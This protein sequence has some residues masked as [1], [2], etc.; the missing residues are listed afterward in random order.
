MPR[1]RFADG[2]FR[3]RLVVGVPIRLVEGVTGNGTANSRTFFVGDRRSS[4][5]EDLVGDPG[6]SGAA[7]IEAAAGDLGE[8]DASRRVK[9]EGLAADEGRG[10][11]SAMGSWGTTLSSA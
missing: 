4:A 8:E 9:L 6:H 2:V 10:G 1:M 3:I 7:R 11:R 5:L